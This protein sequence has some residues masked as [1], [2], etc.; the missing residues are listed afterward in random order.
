L[1]G[2]AV[3]LSNGTFALSLFKVRLRFVLL[4]HFRL[5]VVD[6]PDRPVPVPRRARLSGR[7]A[8]ATASGRFNY[9]SGAAASPVKNYMLRGRIA[10]SSE[11]GPLGKVER[12]ASRP[13]ECGKDCNPRRV[14]NPRRS[15]TRPRESVLPIRLR[16]GFSVV[17]KGYECRAEHW[18]RR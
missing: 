7:P 10:D 5:R 16:P 12:N 14:S 9:R 13:E 17:F 3:G 1:A 2:P 8:T 6:G 11:L 18:P 4:C 15:A